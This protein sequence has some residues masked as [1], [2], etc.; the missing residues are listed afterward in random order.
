MEPPLRQTIKLPIEKYVD[1]KVDILN[2]KIILL[3]K[4]IKDLELQLRRSIIMLERQGKVKNIAISN[5]TSEIS[6]IRK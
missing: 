4:S 1:N 6:R 2:K 3:E 5:L